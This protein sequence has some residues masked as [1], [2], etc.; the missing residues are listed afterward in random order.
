LE[1]LGGFPETSIAEDVLFS[2]ILQG[3]GWFTIYNNEK[4]QY[5][6]QPNSLASHIGQ[7]IKWVSQVQITFKGLIILTIYQCVGHT[8]NSIALRFCVFHPKTK[9]MNRMQRWAAVSYC[10]RPWTIIGKSASWLI[11]AWCLLSGL[12]LVAA[13]TLQDM[14]L[15]LIVHFIFWLLTRL[16]EFSSSRSYGYW[17]L[18]KSG[19]HLIWLSPYL[20]LAIMRERFL[21][22][23]LGGHKLGFTST[24]S[25]RAAVDERNSETRGNLLRRLW[26]M[27]GD[28]WFLLHLLFLG[29]MVY[30]IF[31]NAIHSENRLQLLQLGLFPGI[32]FEHLPA[33]MD[34]FL[35]ACNPPTDVPR[36]SLMEKDKYGVWRPKKEARGGKWTAGIY[37]LEVPQAIITLWAF[38]AI[39]LFV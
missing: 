23:W 37:M 3:H 31:R 35:Y 14:R 26:A 30:A 39:M 34:L 22:T 6:L 25:M 10:I 38:G 17:N 36:R 18:R 15:L 1:A 16:N 5:G 32:G 4:L 33:F 24:G 8:N 20:T 28:T 13:T 11:I 2:W 12:P 29:L 21:P 9:G 7:R 19:N 27:N